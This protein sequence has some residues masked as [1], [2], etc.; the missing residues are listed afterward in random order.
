[1]STNI[2]SKSDSKFEKKC[3]CGE[4]YSFGE[5][6]LSTTRWHTT[7]KSKLWFNCNNCD[8][9]LM[10]LNKEAQKSKELENV[11]EK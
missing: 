3:N 1:M 2:D 11:K 8:S 10:L 7:D 4:K 5:N 6:F 9:T